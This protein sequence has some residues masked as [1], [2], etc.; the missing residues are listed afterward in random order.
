MLYTESVIGIF[1][2]FGFRELPTPETLKSSVLQIANCEFVLKPSAAINKINLG[3]PPQHLSF[4][5]KGSVRGLFSIYM[6]KCVTAEKVLDMFQDAEGGDPNQ[7]RVFTYL[8]QYIGS[9][10][11]EDLGQFLRFVTGSSVCMTGKIAVT[12]NALTGT[13]RRP[14]AHTCEPSLELSSTYSSFLEFIKE[15]RAYTS[16]WEMNAL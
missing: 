6:A 1:S 7:E 14:I 4:W 16:E 2:R 11:K 12:F 8:R 3:I 5:Q 10:N 13:A 15:F 9:M